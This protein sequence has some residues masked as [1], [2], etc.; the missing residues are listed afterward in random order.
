MTR[1]A[2]TRVGLGRLVANLLAGAWRCSPLP[3]SA[4]DL[5]SI[6]NLVTTC[7]AGG[8]A[9]CRIRDSQLRNSEVAKLFRAQYRF[10]SLQAALHERNL[11]RVIPLLRNSG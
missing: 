1:K 4:S 2:R 10:Q 7:G 11:K 3:S 5:A 9:W 8:L 6:A